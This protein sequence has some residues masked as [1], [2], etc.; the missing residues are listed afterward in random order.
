MFDLIPQF[1]WLTLFF[2]CMVALISFIWVIAPFFPTRKNDLEKVNQICK[3]KPGEVFYELGCGDGRVSIHLAKNNPNTQIIGLE[4]AFPLYVTAK[5][6]SLFYPGKNLKIKWKNLFWEDLSKADCL[7]TFAMKESLNKALKNKFKKELKSG[8]RIVS[9][10]FS[11]ESWDGKTEKFPGFRAKT[12][13]YK[14]TV[15]KQKKSK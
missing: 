3:L 11:F 14:Y 15:P 2:L 12:F 10:V 9:Y 7:Y 1:V 8:T 6:K 13:I 4:M 5:I